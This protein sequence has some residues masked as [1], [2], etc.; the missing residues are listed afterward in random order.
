MPGLVPT[1][2]TGVISADDDAEGR[3]G[4]AVRV[5]DKG[6]G[7]GRKGDGSGNGLSTTR[8]HTDGNRATD[9]VKRACA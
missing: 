6:E 5:S 4:E 2:A 3:S 7:V 9:G 8:E 1:P